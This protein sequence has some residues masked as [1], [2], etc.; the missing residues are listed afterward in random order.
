MDDE[1]DEE[2]E[3][4]DDDDDESDTN[5]DELDTDMLD[6]RDSGEDAGICNLHDNFYKPLAHRRIILAHCIVYKATFTSPPNLAALGIGLMSF[7]EDCTCMCVT[8]H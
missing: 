5:D 4:A 6:E 3:D 2:D 7:R 1:D 8:S